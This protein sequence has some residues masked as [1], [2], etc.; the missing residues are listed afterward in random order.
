MPSPDYHAGSASTTMVLI[1]YEL[2]VRH[3][4]KCD[5]FAT[6]SS[7]FVINYHQLFFNCKNTR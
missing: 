1:I 5:V 2:Q 4:M 3:S 7:S 6:I